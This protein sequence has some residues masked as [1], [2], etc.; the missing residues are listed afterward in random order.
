MVIIENKLNNAQEQQCQIEDYKAG[1][2]HKGFNV[3]KTVCLF[4]NKVRV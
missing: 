3:V 4:L 1:L 2:K